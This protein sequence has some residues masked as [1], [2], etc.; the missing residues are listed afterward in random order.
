M[1]L[2]GFTS[3]HDENYKFIGDF[4]DENLEENEI[5]WMK[6]EE[7]MAA[8]KRADMVYRILIMEKNCAQT[9]NHG[10]I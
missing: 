9:I 6:Y 7:T 3:W 8:W 5:Q 10:D 2:I 1:E 4:E